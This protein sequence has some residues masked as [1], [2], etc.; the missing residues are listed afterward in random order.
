MLFDNQLSHCTRKKP[1]KIE[2]RDQQKLRASVFNQ[3][4]SRAFKCTCT[5]T[6]RAAASAARI[7]LDQH[8]PKQT[9]ESC[10]FSAQQLPQCHFLCFSR[11]RLFFSSL[12]RL[13]T[14]CLAW[15]WF[16]LHP[17]PLSREANQRDAREKGRSIGR[18]NTL[19]GACRAAL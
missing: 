8:S 2:R 7:Y 12:L 6:A 9:I 11:G 18:R 3:G 1:R 16:L 13:A 14:G 10:N 19:G 4:V 17:N 15:A 5:I